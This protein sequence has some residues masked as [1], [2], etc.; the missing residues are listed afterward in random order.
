MNDT[1]FYTLNVAAV[2][3]ETDSAVQVI[4]D[5]PAELKEKYRFIQGQYLT[6][7]ADINGEDVRRSY[8]I[9]SA[10]GDDQLRVG[11]KKIDGGAFSTFANDK[12]KTGDT[13]Q[14][15]PPQG[16]FYTELNPANSK[17]Y[18]CI[19]A[20]S[21]ITPMLSIIKTVLATEPDSSVTLIYGNQRTKTVMFREELSD[22][23]NANMERFQWINILSREE[24]D[25][26]VLHGRINNKKG[27]E[28]QAKKLIKINA[29]DEV[30]LCGPESMI[31]EV[32]RGL[33]SEGIAEA[34]IH[35]ELFGSSAEAAAEA[36]AKHHQRAEKYGELVSNVTLMSGGRRIN[37]DLS[38]DGENLLDAGIDNGVDLPF[39]CKGGVCATC[40]AKL[41]EGDVEMDRTHGLEQ[42]EIDKGFILTCQAHPVS[43]KVVVDFDQH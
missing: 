37:F 10:V 13:L 38:A 29:F 18:M 24:H 27:A 30:F 25:A 16:K 39:S 43:E 26:E 20:G 41:V 21:G 9:C 11:I 36:V 7:K 12:L 22:V 19:A 6:L 4:F 33:R 3:P 34:N 17:R 32:S 31:S 40:K 28:L 15:M 14:V 35:Y 1:N 2:V 5:V 8:S 42:Y 23:K